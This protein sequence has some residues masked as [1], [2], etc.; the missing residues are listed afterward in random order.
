MK[1]LAAYLLLGLAGNESPSAKDIKSVLDS[2][3]IEADD[4]RLETLLKEL[5]GKDINEV[6]QTV[7]WRIQLM[8]TSYSSLLPVPK[9]LPAF[10]QVAQVE[11][12]L[13]VVLPP[14]LV[15]PLRPR[16]K[17]RRWRR[18]RSQMMTWD[19]VSSTKRILSRKCIVKASWE[20]HGWHAEPR[21]MCRFFKAGHDQS[22]G[23]MLRMKCNELFW[24]IT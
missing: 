4:E 7:H 23:F 10:H 21:L 24:R 22:W 20:V 15:V 17:R 18:R 19:S 6:R 2:V 9:S 12:L 13:L 11:V 16:R 3:G 1:H 5:K 8:L 14:L